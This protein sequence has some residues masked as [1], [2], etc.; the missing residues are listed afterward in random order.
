MYPIRVSRARLTHGGQHIPT[1]LPSLHR[2]VCTR[3][4]RRQTLAVIEPFQIAGTYVVARCGTSMPPDPHKPGLQ[5]NQCQEHFA[6]TDTRWRK[7]PSRNSVCDAVFVRLKPYKT[8]TPKTLPN[9]IP[10]VCKQ[11]SSHMVGRSRSTAIHTAYPIR[12]QAEPYRVHLS[13]VPN[14]FCRIPS[15]FPSQG[16]RHR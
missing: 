15:V 3:R 8:G 13:R 5:S 6:H 12:T 9:H 10:R 4:L 2:R 7:P 14:P 1:S 11:C 16:G